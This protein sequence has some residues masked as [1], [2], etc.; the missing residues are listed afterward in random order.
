[1]S[2]SEV[3]DDICDLHELMNCAICNGD[4]KRS[5]QSLMIPPTIDGRPPQIPGGPTI[6]AKFPGNCTGCG[7]RYD[8]N[9]AIHHP[10]DGDGW[11]GVDC[12][13]RPV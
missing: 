12:C 2:Q 7:R 6:F 4:L 8:R 11:L 5:E 13:V 3:V 9:D 10:Q 1:M